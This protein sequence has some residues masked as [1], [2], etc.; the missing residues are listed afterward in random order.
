MVRI[1]FSCYEGIKN[2][3][4]MSDIH[5]DLE[6]LIINLRY[7]AK[8]I[9]I[10]DDTDWRI[11]ANESLPDME[12]NDILKDTDYDCLFG[13]KWCGND[14]YVVII[15]DILDNYR[16]PST[17]PDI[18][19]PNKRQ[20]EIEHEE[21]KIFLFLQK[22]NQTA[23]NSNGKVI[24]MIGN[25]EDMNLRSLSIDIKPYISNYSLNTEFNSKDRNILFIYYNNLLNYVDYSTGGWTDSKKCVIFKINDF[26]FLHGGIHPEMIQKLY[27]ELIL[28]S[29]KT[30]TNEDKLNILIDYINNVYN[31]LYEEHGHELINNGPLSLLWYRGIGFYETLFDYDDKNYTKF[32]EWFNKIL[33]ILCKDCTKK[34]IIVGHC[35]QSTYYT[36]DSQ[37]KYNNNTHSIIK[38]EGNVHIIN[39]PIISTSAEIE[40][41]KFNEL[42]NK[43]KSC[44]QYETFKLNI[45]PNIFGI[46]N[47]CIY[48]E[49]YAQI[50]RVD[51]GASRAFD[52]S[53]HDES[54]VK[55]LIHKISNT[56]PVSRLL[57]N[58]SFINLFIKFMYKYYVSRL[59][60]ILHIK[61]DDQTTFTFN[62]VR[63]TLKNAIK[64]MPRNNV[65]PFNYPDI[66][67]IID[68]IIEIIDSN[69]KYT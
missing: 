65:F 57:Y 39:G 63:S 50:Y 15:G 30:Y 52:L 66:I 68:F 33:N 61:Y 12:P 20:N 19:N 56:N 54:E 42:S 48:D 44:I 10:D 1:N 37:N 31:K 11:L 2:I 25:H 23:Q 53:L 69:V 4:V 34:Y 6:L 47:A 62:I 28:D 13:F 45:I 7:C 26:I 8:V 36:H 59:P 9:N 67:P 41:N 24:I 58:K 18:K 3:C 46:T 22:L 60:Q 49:I 29:S 40:L 64:N 27:E 35:I 51:I 21:L 16:H 55:T 32:C 14:T 17:V 38:K 43:K 5:G